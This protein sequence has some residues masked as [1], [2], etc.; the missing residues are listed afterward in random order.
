MDDISINLVMT[1]HGKPC[2]GDH[3]FQITLRP[4]SADQLLDITGVMGFDCL[5]IECKDTNQGVTSRNL[6]D[7]L[8]KCPIPALV[9][10]PAGS[11]AELVGALRANDDYCVLSDD[12]A[13][14][15]WRVKHLCRRAVCEP[16]TGRLRR[17][18]FDRQLKSLAASATAE[19][20]VTFVH[21]DLDRFKSINLQFGPSGGDQVLQQFSELLPNDDVHIVGRI[22]GDGFGIMAVDWDAKTALDYAQKLLLTTAGHK[23]TVGDQHS[24]L[25]SLTISIGIAT[26]DSAL[27]AAAVYQQAETAIYVAKSSG[28]NRVAHFSQLEIDSD[29]DLR[30]KSLEAVEQVTHE[31]T[32]A[33]LRQRRRDL[34]AVLK[35]QAERDHLTGLFNRR[36]LDRRVSPLLRNRLTTNPPICIAMLDVDRF[37]DINKLPGLWHTGDRT[38]CHVAE[39]L[40]KNVRTSDWVVRYSG[41]EFMIVFPDCHLKTAQQISARICDSIAGHTFRDAKSGRPF[42]LT[43]SMG[44][45]EV[46][47]G[48]P[49]SV[50]WQRLS[51]RLN[52]AKKQGRNQVCC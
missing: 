14:W 46:R 3:A 5:L 39:L 16:L 36:Y 4:V 26:I 41:D 45:V 44:V 6:Q 24:D 48:E 50:V 28:R 20:P 30:I 2:D 38:L 17:S 43:V 23:F 35:N 12:A 32:E 11:I 29:S 15:Q 25:A 27:P 13:D 47:C 22:A 31:R 42:S 34:L 18:E 8:A 40:S 33:F 1:S 10:M 21:V 7:V 52:V 19:H 37:G 49:D 9:R 51:E